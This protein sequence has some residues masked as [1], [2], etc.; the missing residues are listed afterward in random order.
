MAMAR[1]ATFGTRPAYLDNLFRDSPLPLPTSPSLH[2]STSSISCSS[3]TSGIDLRLNKPLPR[4][5]SPAF[6]DIAED[7]GS[8]RSLRL[9]LSPRFKFR[10]I[11]NRRTYPTESDTSGPPSS[12]ISPTPSRPASRR[13]SLPK[14]NTS[15]PTT[16]RRD[17][18][19]PYKPLP[20]APASSAHELPCHRCYYFAARNCNG[21]VMGGSHGDACEQCLVRFVQASWPRWLLT[22]K[23]NSKQAS[24]ARHKLPHCDDVLSIRGVYGTSA[25]LQWSIF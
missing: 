1:P 9:N 24:L 3:T 19:L 4:P 11:L 20:T 6:E 18:P 16:T 5:L 14:L 13:P 8:V 2:S 25:T 15:F 17:K 10:N 7:R 21:Y 22:D 23:H 12:T